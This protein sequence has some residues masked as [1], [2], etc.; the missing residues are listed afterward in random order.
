MLFKYDTVTTLIY[1]QFIIQYTSMVSLYCSSEAAAS[2]EPELWMRV[3]VKP[4]F[5]IP[6]LKM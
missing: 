5:N 6:F 1:I 3:L 4:G 2:K